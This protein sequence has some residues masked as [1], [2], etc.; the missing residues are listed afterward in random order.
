[1]ILCCYSFWRL[2]YFSE[3][4]KICKGFKGKLDIDIR[5]YECSKRKKDCQENITF[6]NGGA[7]GEYIVIVKKYAGTSSP[8]DITLII[9][10]NGQKSVE[11]FTLHEVN[12]EKVF[13][14]IH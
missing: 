3:K 12:D 10:N 4:E 6:D 11:E 8:T 5:E 14:I 9:I 1:M 2:I 7:R 13:K